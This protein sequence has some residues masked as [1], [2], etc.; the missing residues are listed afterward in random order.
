MNVSFFRMAA[1]MVFDCTARTARSRPLVWALLV[2]GLAS[3]SLLRETSH[4]SFKDESAVVIKTTPPVEESTTLPSVDLIKTV[5]SPSL[6]TDAISTA[7]MPLIVWLMS[8]PNSGTSYTMTMVERA[9]NLSTASNYGAEVTDPA[10]VSLPL[11]SSHPEGPYWEGLSGKLG[12]IRHLPDRFVLTKTHCGGRC[13]NCGAEE[14]VVSTEQFLDD[15]SRTSALMGP[16]N[17][18]AVQMM[19][20]KRVARMVHLLR[21]PYQNIV[22]RF[23]LE[24]RHFVLRD[25]KLAITFPNNATGFAAWCRKLDRLYADEE[26]IL[27]SK[28]RDLMQKLPCHAEFYKYVQWHNKALEI[29]PLM[30]GGAEVPMWTI[31]Y[32][33]YQNNFNSTVKGLMDFLELSIV[34]TPREFRALPD[35]SDHFS[36]RDR[37]HAN[38]LMNEVATS[39][40]RPLIERYLT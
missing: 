1:T 10:D 4:V 8:Y 27:E 21:N 24:R 23:H 19:N 39:K 37:Q 34:S 40:T 35:Y 32:E 13:V 18:R 28:V 2:I 33:D 9:S 29:G 15:C 38:A 16:E 36:D 5:E 14:Y 25:P 26:S 6:S 3:Y 22:A 12:A 30:N 7:E 20:P 31:H 17:S 11:H